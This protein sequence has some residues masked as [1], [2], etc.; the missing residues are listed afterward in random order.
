M[1]LNKRV[2]GILIGHGEF[3]KVI[4]TTVEQFI[5]KQ[6]DIEI[7]SNNNCSAVE[8]KNRLNSAIEKFHG[9]DVI[10]FVDLQGGSCDTISR[11]VLSQTKEQKL[12]IICGVNVATLI[13]YFQYR[14]RYEFKELLEL[15]SES[16]KKDITTIA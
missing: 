1:T 4:L 6:D 5:G 13:K 11:Q 15:L 10:I 8:L 9:K 16:G 14:D 7:V 12:G 2:C 3:P